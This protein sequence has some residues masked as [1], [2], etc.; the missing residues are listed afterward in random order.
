MAK[1]CSKCGADLSADAVFCP[2]CGTS[3]TAKPA[4]QPAQAQPAP[5]APPP[6]TGGGLSGLQGFVDLIFSRL[7]ITLV[8]IIGALMAWIGALIANFTSYASQGSFVG[9]TGLAGIGLILLCAGFLNNKFDKYIRLGMI[10]VGGYILVTALASISNPASGISNAFG[11][12]F[13][14]IPTL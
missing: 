13:N 6:K 7:V 1:K 14:N 9:T 10:V 11:S 5:V 2:L 8:I 4:K 3:V 12:V